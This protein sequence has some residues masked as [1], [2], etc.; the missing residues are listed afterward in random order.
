MGEV[1]LVLS[2]YVY[3]G[4]FFAIML[5]LIGCAVDSRRH[6][7]ELGK[8]VAWLDLA[9]IP[10]ILGNAIII[11]AK[12]RMLALVGCYIYYVGMDFV[13]YQL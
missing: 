7:K 11:L 5:T 13:I 6:Y 10:P 9:F 3:S 8:A 12:R 4:I 2:R 1:R